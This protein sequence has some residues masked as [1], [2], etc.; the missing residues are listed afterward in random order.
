MD[1]AQLLAEYWDTLAA[2][3]GRELLSLLEGSGGP[4]VPPCLSGKGGTISTPNAGAELQVPHV[5][6]GAQDCLNPAL[7][8]HAPAME[9][10]SNEVSLPGPPLAA[11]APGSPLTKVIQPLSVF[12]RLCNLCMAGEGWC[13]SP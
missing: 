10:D 6:P 7:C 4:V 3:E 13:A 11:A 1:I 9:V 5:V 2:I 12:P 8:M